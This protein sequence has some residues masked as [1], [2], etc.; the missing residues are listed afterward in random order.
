MSCDYPNTQEQEVNY[1]HTY[2][3]TIDWVNLLYIHILHEY[4]NIYV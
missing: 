1:I 3:C 4:T 2:I